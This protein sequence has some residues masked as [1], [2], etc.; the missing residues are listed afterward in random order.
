[1]S[2]ISTPLSSSALKM[3]VFSLLAHMQR[4]LISLPLTVLINVRKSVLSPVCDMAV[5][6]L[7]TNRSVP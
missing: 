2:V 4:G 1:M 3:I 7:S 6:V 5:I